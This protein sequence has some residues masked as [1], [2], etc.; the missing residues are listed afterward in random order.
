MLANWR[1]CLILHGQSYSHQVRTV[2]QSTVWRTS[3]DLYCASFG[4]MSTD[5][6]KGFYFTTIHSIFGTM[7]NH[8]YF[9]FHFGHYRQEY[10]LFLMKRYT[11][12]LKRKYKILMLTLHYSAVL[13]ASWGLKSMA[14]RLFVAFCSGWHQWKIQSSVLLALC[15]G[16]QPQLPLHKRSPW[17]QLYRHWKQKF[18][19]IMATLNDRDGASNYRSIACLFNCFFFRLT[20]KEHQ[21]SA[22][23][24]LC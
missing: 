3:G 14:T 2:Y 7:C 4:R 11:A 21:R 12:A 10:I 6:D 17:C 5:D 20:T 23:L 24:V 18:S 15:G 19:R 9:S 8:L 22:S 13:W 1:S 16:N